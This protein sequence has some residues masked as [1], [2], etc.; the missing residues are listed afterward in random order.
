MT[1]LIKWRKLKNNYSNQNTFF[2]WYTCVE[3]QIFKIKDKLILVKIL[4][5]LK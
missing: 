5:Y 4:V 2:G 1:T 3:T